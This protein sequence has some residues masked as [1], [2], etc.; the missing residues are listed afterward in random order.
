MRQMLI[1]LT[2]GTWLCL[3]VFLG[4][5]GL[6][7]SSFVKVAAAGA[8][9]TWLASRGLD[10]TAAAE[11]PSSSPAIAWG[12][13]LA[14]PVIVAGVMGFALQREASPDDYV[15][16]A[17][18]MEHASPMVRWEV[19]QC[20]EDDRLSRFESRTLL[21]TLMND[22]GILT[23]KS[24]RGV[25]ADDARRLLATELQRPSARRSG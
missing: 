11:R 25:S 19:Q 21:R 20:L 12:V 3:A 14:A 7:L 17:E 1:P 22:V 6:S 5:S 13:S 4:I 8:F 9:F 16:L 23:F 2:F 18:N 10:K 15:N 24:E